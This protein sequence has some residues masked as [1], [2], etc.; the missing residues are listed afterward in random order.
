MYTAWASGIFLKKTTPQTIFSDQ[1]PQLKDPKNIN[2]DSSL[3]KWVFQ[4]F[5]AAYLIPVFLVVTTPAEAIVGGVKAQIGQFPYIVS[6][7]LQFRKLWVQISAIN[8]RETQV[9]VL[10]GGGHACGGALISDR[11]NLKTS[12]QKVIT[13]HSSFPETFPIYIL[14]D[15]KVCPH[16]SWMLWNGSHK[17][18]W[19]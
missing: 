9:S 13:L 8:I 17:W 11:F 16:F 1:Y 6:C 3:F 7:S 12:F 10:H 2:C 5:Y 19:N 15:A 4:M 18:G 14:F